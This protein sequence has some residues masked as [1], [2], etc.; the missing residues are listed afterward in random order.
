MKHIKL[1]RNERSKIT[2]ERI[3]RSALNAFAKHGFENASV[4]RITADAKVSVGSFYNYFETKE[5]LLSQVVLS[6]GLELRRSIATVVSN[7]SNF[8]TREEKS[9]RQYF[10]FLQKHPYYIQILNESEIFLPDAY[11]ELVEHILEGYRTVLCDAS[12]KREIR[13]LEGVE[14]EGVA[15][16]LMAARHYYGQHFLS[17]CD[18]TGEL[19]ENI[20]TIYLRFIQGGLKAAQEPVEELPE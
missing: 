13:P 4:A 16:F 5:I 10:K 1:S 2:K 14:V 8:F 17:L 11:N 7:A 3:S 12:K 15:L 18:S 6:L 9:F 20:V 19:P